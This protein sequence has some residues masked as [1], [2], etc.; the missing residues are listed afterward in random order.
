MRNVRSVT[1]INVLS[2][3][4]L[5]NKKLAHWVSMHYD[6]VKVILCIHLYLVLQVYQ[7]DVGVNPP[8]PSAGQG[9]QRAPIEIQFVENEDRAIL[10]LPYELGGWRK[11]II[12]IIF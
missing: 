2:L 7:Q 9:K 5:L 6:F 11:Y 4:Q 1:N 10:V 12:L 8:G 3:R